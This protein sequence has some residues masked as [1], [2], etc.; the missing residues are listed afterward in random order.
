MEYAELTGRATARI[1]RERRIATVCLSPATIRSQAGAVGIGLG[2]ATM[3][4]RD[5]M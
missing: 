3:S 4:V 2:G 5:A 1:L